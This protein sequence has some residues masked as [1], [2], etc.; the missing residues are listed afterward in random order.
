MRRYTLLSLLPVLLAF[1]AP[2]SAA[3]E[4]LRPVFIQYHAPMPAGIAGELNL[5]GVPNGVVVPSINAVA[6]TAPDALIAVIAQ[7]SRVRAIRAQ[8]RLQLHLYG[9]V[10]QIAA[11]DVDVPE[12]T[13]EA[14]CPLERPGVTGAG[15]TVAVVDSGV[16]AAHPA[17]LGR[18]LE[19]R[20]FELSLLQRE[21]S[22]VL[23][24]EE[25]DLYATA[26]GP[27]ALQDEVGHG[28]HCAGII[29]G[30][31]TGASGLDLRGVAPGVNM[32]SMKIASAV[33]GVVEDIGFEANSVMALDYLVRHHEELGVRVA[34]NSWGLLAEEVQSPIFGATDFDPVAEV[35]KAAH[36]EGIV[37]VF[38]AGNDG[39]DA[40]NPAIRAV[41]NAMDEV[42]AVASACKADNGSCAGGGIN[43]FS[44]RGAAVD[45]AAPGDQ[46]LSAMSPSILAPIGQALEGSYFGDSPQDEVANR[47]LYMRLSGTSMSAPHVAGVVALLLEANPDLSPEQVREVLVNTADDMIGEEGSELLEGF[48]TASGFGMVNTRKA[49]AT[50]MGAPY[51]ELPATCKVSAPAARVQGRFGGALA[52]LLLLLLVSAAGLRAFRIQ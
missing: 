3:T 50:A 4:V 21:L 19:G 41:P 31:G 38:S 30:D 8:R 10:S 25:W 36:A 27:T 35:V 40:E 23:S 14:S 46:I 20:N 33:N 22:G 49:L 12:M 28:T 24:A 6:V 9:S 45:V 43:G 47:A 48:D 5:L 37:L 42:I 39:G 32:V 34:S 16:F 2:L 44:S 1:S 13:G 52:P 26:S 15:V 18:V 7:D 11:R 17:L 29:G 51:A